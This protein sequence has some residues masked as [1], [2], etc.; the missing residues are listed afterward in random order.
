[1][2]LFVLVTLLTFWNLSAFSL[3]ERLTESLLSGITL[4]MAMIPEEFPV[5]LTVFLSMG[6][7]RLAKKHAL[8]KEIPLKRLE[9]LPE[10]SPLRA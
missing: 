9:I 6:A 10:S 3:R 5:V 8:V 1:M 2:G 4:S 7:W